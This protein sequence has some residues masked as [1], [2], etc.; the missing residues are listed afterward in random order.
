MNWRGILIRP[1]E[2]W[3]RVVPE[4][5]FWS[6]VPSPRAGVSLGCCLGQG[7][8]L[9]GLQLWSST[10]QTPLCLVRRQI[11]PSTKPCCLELAHSCGNSKPLSTALL[12]R[13]SREL[14]RQPAGGSHICELGGP[15]EAQAL[16][17]H[18]DLGPFPWEFHIMQRWP[19]KESFVE[20][21]PSP[22]GHGLAADTDVG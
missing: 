19:E 15:G 5:K 17:R 3:E 13:C 6:E 9:P 11:L 21:V 10:A 14:G 1:T 22:S 2:G 20:I 4:V 18:P 16:V 12:F 8:P 7:R